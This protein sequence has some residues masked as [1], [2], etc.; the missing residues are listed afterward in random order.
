MKMGAPNVI[1]DVERVFS[2][3]NSSRHHIRPAII[4]FSYLSCIFTYVQ[5]FV[6]YVFI[7]QI[8]WSKMKTEDGSKLFVKDEHSFDGTRDMLVFFYN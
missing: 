1:D 5:M 7:F 4:F 3:S 6:F 2:H 8:F